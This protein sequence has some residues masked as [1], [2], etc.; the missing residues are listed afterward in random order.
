MPVSAL[1]IAYKESV[2]TGTAFSYNHY[3]LPEFRGSNLDSNPHCTQACGSECAK[4]NIKDAI[5]FVVGQYNVDREYIFV[6]GLSGGGH[7]ALL[8]A[9]FCPEYFKAVGVFVPITDLE[10]WQEQNPCYAKH[11]LACCSNNIEEMK[12]RHPKA[13]V[14][15]DVFDGGH[16]IDMEVAMYWFFSQY[17]KKEKSKVTG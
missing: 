16:E 8:M 2:S 4:Q 15:L 17:E 5:G 12:K 3:L 13:S 10:K 14:Y 6:L 7:M 11:V 1:S 9:G